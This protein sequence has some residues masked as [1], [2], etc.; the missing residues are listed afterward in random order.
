MGKFVIDPNRYVKRNTKKIQHRLIRTWVSITTKD[1]N[2]YMIDDKMYQVNRGR[3]T[4][5]GKVC[6]MYEGDYTSIPAIEII[7]D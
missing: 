2:L 7:K 5:I 4:Y 6:D 3:Y 1:G